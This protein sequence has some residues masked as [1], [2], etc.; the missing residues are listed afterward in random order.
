MKTK[1]TLKNI[2]ET[3]H[4]SISTVSRAL[5]NHPDISEETKRKVMELASII[6]YEPNTH[7]INLRTNKSKIFGLIVP[8]IS[9]FFYHSFISS[10]EE[11]ARQ[12]GYSLLILQSGND[13]QI[14]LDNL[15]LCR[16]NR[17]AGVFVSIATHTKEIKPFLKLDELDIPV[18]FFD[19][20]PSFEACNKICL[21]DA[22]AATLAAQVI[23]EKNKKNVLAIFGN[24]ELSI[25]QKRQ[26]AFSEKLSSHP[27]QINVI[28]TNA[29]SSAEA[30]QLTLQFCSSQQRPDT[31][32]S[33]SDE[34]LTG[35]MKG[36]QQLTLKIP[37]DISVLSICNNNFIPELYDPVI[38]FIE[39][40]GSDLGK[41]A[42]K[43]MMDHLSGKTFVQQLTVPSRLIEGG[44][45]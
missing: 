17:V 33:M 20:V 40:S 14:E 7:A 37:S 3:L 23:L 22:E 43:R 36:I 10:V 25:T 38:T 28:I 18:I 4:L 15:K 21:A 6:E 41:L 11:E 1:A 29:D 26:K 34:I 44:S 13:T 31:I 45:I 5:K 42:F 9:N 39:T 32:F 2:S 30:L 24:T 35:V 12:I 27:A 16:L 19:K 8:V